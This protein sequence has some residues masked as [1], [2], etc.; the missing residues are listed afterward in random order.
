MPGWREGWEAFEPD[1]PM[2][3]PT[4]STPPTPDQLATSD[5]MQEA[6]RNVGINT[7]YNKLLDY[8]PDIDKF[9]AEMAQFRSQLETVQS[10]TD[11]L[12]YEYFGYSLENVRDA[13]I[14]F[15]QGTMYDLRRKSELYYFWTIHSMDGTYPN[16]PPVGYYQWYP[17]VR[18]YSLVTGNESQPVLNLARSITLGAVIQ[19]EMEPRGIEGPTKCNPYNK[20]IDPKELE[21]LISIYMSMTF[22]ELDELYATAKEDSPLGPPLPQEAAEKQAHKRS[23]T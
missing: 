13:F 23:Q 20:P 19:E 7:P 2:L 22:P 12:L 16:E 8:Y 4:N 5:R 14:L 10:I 11:E 9:K 3:R 18:A 21:R 1:P 6:W 15:G 17:W